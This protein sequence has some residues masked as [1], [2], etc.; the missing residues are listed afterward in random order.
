MPDLDG[1]EVE[2]A[3]DEQ[4]SASQEHTTPVADNYTV[5]LTGPGLSL[6]RSVHGQVA[7][8]IM[9]LVMTPGG[10]VPA[11]ATGPAATGAARHSEPPGVSQ[12][13]A[14]PRRAVGEFVRST[15]AKRNVDKFVAIGVWIEDELGQQNFTRDDVKSQF[16][17][18]GERAPQN[19][20]RDFQSAVSLNWLAP[21]HNN[22]NNFWVTQSGRDAM[23]AQFAGAPAPR[24][25]RSKR[26]AT[27]STAD[28]D[29]A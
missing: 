23:A 11:Q 8:Q 1:N 15:G 27:D 6:K 19:M 3:G 12:P 2:A 9:G 22:P 26:K 18:L 13:P 21:D 14:Q 20:S 28:K 25:A 10:V 7:L 16:R 5:E 4:V 17:G 29:E 24:R